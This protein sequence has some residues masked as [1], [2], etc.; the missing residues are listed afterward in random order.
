MGYQMARYFSNYNFYITHPNVTQYCILFGG[1]KYE[2]KSAGAYEFLFLIGHFIIGFVLGVMYSYPL[3]QIIIITII[4]VLLLFYTLGIRPFAFKLYFIIEIITQILLI[5]ALVGLAISIAYEKSG[6]YDCFSREGTLCY[7]ILFALFAYLLLLALGLML[8]ALLAGCLGSKTFYK[9]KVDRDISIMESGSHGNNFEQ[10]KRLSPEIGGFGG[11]TD[12]HKETYVSGGNIANFDSEEIHISREIK[13]TEDVHHTHVTHH[14]GVVKVT[15]VEDIMEEEEEIGSKSDELSEHAKVGFEDSDYEEISHERNNGQTMHEF[16]RKLN[17]D[18]Y[19]HNNK[20]HFRGEYVSN[21]NAHGQ[22]YN[23]GHHLGSDR[24]MK[25]KVDTDDERNKQIRVLHAL[26]HSD[27][28]NHVDQENEDQVIDAKRVVE[29]NKQSH[30]RNY[31]HSNNNAEDNHHFETHHR[32]NAHNVDDRHHY[33][34]HHHD[35]DTSN[36]KNFTLRKYQRDEFICE[37]KEEVDKSYLEGTNVVRT[38]VQSQVD[39]DNL[40]GMKELADSEDYFTK[41]YRHR[42]N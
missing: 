38:R 2:N 17:E 35:K 42:D 37:D 25:L 34:T 23:Y 5:I 6:C 18:N 10:S 30:M 3:A 22:G 15:D 11:H 32:A 26:Q 39:Q 14:S 1:Y 21:M 16:R 7:L 36:T 20:K 41:K 40:V 9:K 31:N 8:F 27:V 24:T 28:N 33:E 4:C 12:F 19:Y 13:T 29:I